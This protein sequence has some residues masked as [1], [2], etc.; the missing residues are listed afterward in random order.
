MS[1]INEHEESGLDSY[2]NYPLQFPKWEKR[3]LTSVGSNIGNLVDPRRTRENFRRA[4]MD[5]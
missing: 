1:N 2:P 4:C 3:T 5:L